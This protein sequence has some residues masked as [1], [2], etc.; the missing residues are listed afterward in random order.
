MKFLMVTLVKKTRFCSFKNN[1]RTFLSNNSHLLF[2]F[3]V[4]I[5]KNSPR[6]VWCGRACVCVLFVVGRFLLPICLVDGMG[7][8]KE[9][10]ACVVIV[11]ARCTRC[12]RDGRSAEGKEIKFFIF[13][14]FLIFFFCEFCLCGEFPGW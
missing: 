11:V 2:P 6:V 4:Y 1:K 12:C 9:R 13:G 10:V 7:G 14:F 8:R 3:P 5:S